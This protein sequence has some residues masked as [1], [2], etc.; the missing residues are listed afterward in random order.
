[1]SFSVK[2]HAQKATGESQTTVEAEAALCNRCMRCLHVCPTK[3]LRVRAGGPQ[4][5]G[6]L[7]IDCGECIRACP[8][9]ALRMRG[10]APVGIIP[11]DAVLVVHPALLVQTAFS[12]SPNMV[13]NALLKKGYG[14]IRL[15]SA[16]EDSLRDAASKYAEDESEVAP[17]VSPVCPAV[18]NLIAVR[19][20]SLIVHVAPFLSPIESAREEMKDRNTCFVPLCPAE[21]AVLRAGL[22]EKHAVIPAS[23]IVTA[24]ARDLCEEGNSIGGHG[25][26]KEALRDVCRQDILRAS[27][28]SSVVG[29]LEE[30]ENGS[31]ESVKVLELHACRGGCFGSPLL[32]EHPDVAEYHWSLA[33]VRAGVAGGAVRR[34]SLLQARAGM[35]LDAEMSEALKKV[36]R[37]REITEILPGK[38]CGMCG[39]PTC[40]SLAID[41]VAGRAQVEECVHLPKKQEN[42]K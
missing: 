16:W 29:L 27:G 7:C 14:E 2:L 15:L 1:V 38:D 23:D 9:G 42:R 36:A 31:L 26:G 6:H 40:S 8:A 34:S 3:A 35:S 41:V 33:R 4:I 32:S 25:G 11:G 17:V 24:T 18:L 21:L 37:V 28:M 19:F 10:I 30:V 22:P 12:K 13:L 39:A 5:L 20:P